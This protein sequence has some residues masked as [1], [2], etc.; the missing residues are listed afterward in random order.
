MMTDN[1]VLI[2]TINVPVLM[3]KKSVNIATINLPVVMTEGP[4]YNDK[5][6]C[7]DDREECQHCRNQC[8]ERILQ[9]MIGRKVVGL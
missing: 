7:G 4:H 3:T 6:S 2:V 8:Y 5:C 1:N 9:I